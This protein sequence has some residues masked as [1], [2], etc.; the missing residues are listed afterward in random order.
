M[1]AWCLRSLRV[2]AC[3]GV[4]A[5]GNC[6]SI[7]E[8]DVPDVQIQYEDHAGEPTVGGDDRRSARRRSG[9]RFLALGKSESESCYWHSRERLSLLPCPLFSRSPLSVHAPPLPSTCSFGESHGLDLGPRSRAVALV[10]SPQRFRLA[11][12]SPV[13]ARSPTSSLSSNSTSS[14]SSNPH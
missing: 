8:Q 13:R 3:T 7:H 4:D 10:P 6:V 12:S 11:P 9:Q 14:P 2:F 1:C 5:A